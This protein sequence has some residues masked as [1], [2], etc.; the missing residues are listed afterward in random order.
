MDR[1][2]DVLASIR[3]ITSAS[4]SSASGSPSPAADRGQHR[5]P[6]APSE[7]ADYGS[8][9]RSPAGARSGVH[10][11]A[12]RFMLAAAAGGAMVRPSALAAYDVVVALLC[13]AAVTAERRPRSWPS[14][15]CL[16]SAAAAAAV[17][18]ATA[19]VAR[20]SALVAHSPL[21]ELWSGGC[22]RDP[23]AAVPEAVLLAAL[24]L[25]HRHSQ[26]RQIP[27]PAASAG[28]GSVLSGVSP[29]RFE[30]EP[31]RVWTQLREFA[32][33]A[34]PA[35]VACAQPSV[36]TAPHL[37][38]FGY[39]LCRTFIGEAT[40][41]E[42]RAASFSLRVYSAAALLAHVLY[43]GVLVAPS[44]AHPGCTALRWC[45]SEPHALLLGQPWCGSSGLARA[46]VFYAGLSGCAAGGA[47]A[48]YADTPEGLF[49]V[50]TDALHHFS[51]WIA[52]AFMVVSPT[53]CGGVLMMS[54]VAAAHTHA[55]R[56][57]T[58]APATTAR[59][60][61]LV[62]V[63]AA[64]ASLLWGF[65]EAAAEAGSGG[66]P[67]VRLLAQS[68]LC[69]VVAAIG[70]QSNTPQHAYGE[71][72]LF[73][74]RALDH[75]PPG[76][77]K[78]ATLLLVIVSCA[79]FADPVHVVP[80]VAA[81]VVFAAPSR[82]TARAWW[83]RF[84]LA[85]ELPL[86]L[87]GALLLLPADVSASVQSVVQPGGSSP[88]RVFT[89]V[90]C[91][92][93]AAVQSTRFESGEWWMSRRSLVSAETSEALCFCVCAACVL[94]AM[95]A[96]SVA[97]LSLLALSVFVPFVW[98]LAGVEQ[99]SRRRA[100]E[101][102]AAVS[103]CITVLVLGSDLAPPI[104]PWLSDVLTYG[105][106][107]EYVA[108]TLTI[109]DWQVSVCLLAWAAAALSLSYLATRF[110]LSRLSTISV[111]TAA[112]L[113]LGVTELAPVQT[114]LGSGGAAGCAGG[115]RVAHLERESAARAAGLRVGMQLLRVN[116]LPV[117]GL[118][119][120]RDAAAH[121]SASDG[122]PPAQQED[123]SAAEVL[124][125]AKYR[126]LPHLMSAVVP[127]ALLFASLS[128]GGVYCGTS[129]ANCVN[130]SESVAGLIYFVLGVMS[131]QTRCLRL[132]PPAIGKHVPSQDGSTDFTAGHTRLC[133]GVS[134]AFAT[135]SILGSMPSVRDSATALLGR[136]AGA[137]VVVAG[138]CWHDQGQATAATA[139]VLQLPT[140][141]GLICA[142]AAERLLSP[143]CALKEPHD[144]H[145]TAA[146]SRESLVALLAAGML[147]TFNTVWAVL[148]VVVLC[149]AW[150]GRRVTGGVPFWF[151]VLSGAARYAYGVLFPPADHR[152]PAMAD[153]IHDLGAIAGL[154]TPA[155][156]S[157]YWDVSPSAALLVL[158]Y[159]TAYVAAAVVVIERWSRRWELDFD[160]TYSE[161]LTERLLQVPPDLLAEAELPRT[162]ENLESGL[163]AALVLPRFPRWLR[164]R[165]TSARCAELCG[166]LYRRTG[167]VACGLP[168]WRA[169]RHDCFL[170]AS[171]G[172]WVVV[173]TLAGT[174]EGPAA[175]P[176]LSSASPHLDEPPHMIPGWVEVSQQDEQRVAAAVVDVPPVPV[177][178]ALRGAPRVC[179]GVYG[180]TDM[181][182]NGA[183]VWKRRGSGVGRHLLVTPAGYWVFAARLSA[184]AEKAADTPA[185]V[186]VRRHGGVYPHC[187]RGWK[188]VRQAAGAGSVAVRC[189]D[190]AGH[191]AAAQP[192]GD[193]CADCNP[194]VCPLLP[195]IRPPALSPP[196]PH[197]LRIDGTGGSDG[198]YNLDHSYK[199]HGMPVWRREQEAVGDPRLGVDY[200]F[201][202]GPVRQ[203]LPPRFGAEKSAW[204]TVHARSRE[205]VSLRFRG[206]AG[207]VAVPSAL[208][209][210]CR[211]R[212]LTYTLSTV[213][214]CWCVTD[215]REQAEGTPQVCS[216]SA[217]G[218][219]LLP[220]E[221]DEW[222]PQPSTAPDPR[223]TVRDTGDPSQVWFLRFVVVYPYLLVV[224]AVL[225]GMAGLPSV[226]LV[227]ITFSS[228]G[229]AFLPSLDSVTWRANLHWQLLYR[230]YAAVVLLW[231]VSSVITAATGSAWCDSRLVAA[232]GACVGDFD[233]QA[234]VTTVALT[235]LLWQYGRTLDSSTW[236]RILLFKHREARAAASIGAAIADRQAEAVREAHADFDRRRELRRSA[237]KQLRRKRE[238]LHQLWGGLL[239]GQRRAEPA[240]GS[241]LAARPFSPSYAGSSAAVAAALAVASE[242]VVERHRGV[243]ACERVC[244]LLLRRS[245]QSAD[246]GFLRSMAR[247]YGW[248]VA[249]LWVL[250]EVAFS[251]TAEACYAVTGAHFLAD[252]CVT[253]VLV[254]MSVLL[255]AI[256]SNPRPLFGYWELLLRFYGCVFAFKAALL[257]LQPAASAPLRLMFGWKV[258]LLRDSPSQPFS[259][260]WFCQWE[261]AAFLLIVLH[262][263]GLK[264]HWGLSTDVDVARAEEG[265]SDGVKED[266]GCAVDVEPADDGPLGPWTRYRR[267]L[268]N[269]RHKRGGRDLYSVAFA[270][271]F[272]S[273]VFLIF[274]YAPIMGSRVGFL[275][276]I[277]SNVIPAGLVV[278]VVVLFAVMIT[279]RVVYLSR[280]IH[281][282]AVLHC[283]LCVTYLVAY[284]VYTHAAAG[285]VEEGPLRQRELVG[286]PA[287]V[288]QALCGIKLLYLALS[289]MQLREGY[290]FAERRMFF[291]GK[292][293][294]ASWYLYLGCY[295]I[296]FLYELRC[297]V[298]WA[299]TKTSLKLQYWL[300]LEDV[301][302]E[303]HL[304][305][306]QK[307]DDR[308]TPPGE[309]PRSWKCGS[310]FAYCGAITVLVFFPLAW[311]SSLSPAFVTSDVVRASFKVDLIT[312]GRS[313]GIYSGSYDVT[314]EERRR[315]ESLNVSLTLPGPAWGRALEWTRPSLSGLGLA[316]GVA[317]TTQ[318][319]PFPAMS[320]SVWG[321]SGAALS[322][323]RASLRRGSAV[324]IQLSLKTHR[325][326]APP[327]IAAVG[328]AQTGTLGPEA[329]AALRGQL[330]ALANGTAANGTAPVTLRFAYT[331][332]A[333]VGTGMT[334]FRDAEKPGTNYVACN[335]SV[336]P[337]SSPSDSFWKVL[338]STLFDRGNPPPVAAAESAVPQGFLSG[339]EAACLQGDPPSVSACA[340]LRY[341]SAG[342]PPHWGHARG[343]Y[344]VA[345]SDRVTAGTGV[346][347]VI[348][349]IGVVALYTTFVFAVHRVL[350]AAFTGEAHRIQ[351]RAMESP[352]S[353]EEVISFIHAARQEGDLA[354]EKGLYDELVNLFRSPEAMREWVRGFD[355]APGAVASTPPLHPATDDAALSPILGPHT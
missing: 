111:P 127:T 64:A 248:G 186:T 274:G 131:A 85:V 223:I 228:A 174:A 73:V 44:A 45:S 88:Q 272:L 185:V 284:L 137:W 176:H 330:D 300:R 197:L 253:T 146:R 8:I 353:V 155:L 82:D 258:L 215:F 334:F 7:P 148:T 311:Y 329:R 32:R 99:L 276:S 81:A 144:P 352:Q 252:P 38:V 36:V 333:F 207:L 114:C 251:W 277:T 27:P 306:C 255:Y 296:P 209:A 343:P 172:H 217:H 66:S 269:E 21:L 145:R 338:C 19:L 62:L 331:P 290:A 280:R 205:S 181:Q 298:D 23:V 58:S 230:L 60:A 243:S 55:R 34:L 126:W 279:E 273:F 90:C 281:A 153:W 65:A 214:G 204:A 98:G 227:S 135:L 61:L 4:D 179:C 120:V 13:S 303:V 292:H 268:L 250:E 270:V 95:F 78:M 220:S 24:L 108:A 158:F 163:E 236:A 337:A 206:V 171:G 2:Q 288:L 271:D 196:P 198:V 246:L 165:P 182:V 299:F 37:L 52:A 191:P 115:L 164:V 112:L 106:K 349:S 87:H 96:S 15:R 203:M 254:V 194:P 307:E 239:A 344:L 91:L 264:Y 79:G 105:S 25:F 6:D 310:F 202:V 83:G 10:G 187:A 222:E 138:G 247:K 63:V 132:L 80:F 84:L 226:S 94:A 40:L 305:L 70:S 287:A 318:L 216:V 212:Q 160:G 336:V 241:L 113:E 219:A 9:Q 76:T 308:K 347:R 56:S 257:S 102:S 121:S 210:E 232:V 156:S 141:V 301:S 332:F 109:G 341:D 314:E 12:L 240:S 195:S 159:T 180:I 18:P 225:H 316:H 154:D 218:E 116:G 188:L 229:I 231:L 26:A 92:S 265:L 340:A 267:N 190:Q 266:G 309:Y 50:S 175:T 43:I 104:G 46:V 28:V 169:T 234:R 278:A 57:A 237:L 224:A 200:A 59:I 101:F 346:W 128:G 122:G 199:V 328:S 291:A 173:E 33:V 67:L 335:F 100:A 161:G 77:A 110:P 354:L 39:R 133:L 69:A 22:V 1:P 29:G 208:W 93:A 242:G 293:D 325:T 30:P 143:Y 289:A 5:S 321:V 285:S 211:P 189:M 327:S 51:L 282:K 140:H 151:A 72:T 260:L 245:Y 20:G 262:R 323:F 326:K 86:V 119:C 35:A 107:P 315:L 256:C 103:W 74:L 97:P 192:A 233:A 134:T 351:V 304:G 149:V 124:R 238:R 157:G 31:V 324:G 263:R 152:F 147:L 342:S 170:R 117:S 162:D 125:P 184:D 68:A 297:V 286:P 14:L 193:D 249:W 136:S 294:L 313:Y 275:E 41:S 49:G 283:T 235:A 54:A 319:V 259:L 71:P 178:L 89:L 317:R 130:V 213:G 350:R 168:V 48:G 42:G 142:C 167:D 16:R 177:E 295:A 47:K 17:L 355:A 322:S 261:L 139:C 150:R 201:R 221:I 3:S 312:D 118:S 320:E 339:P 345:M 183:P 129:T 166:G 75:L 11:S 302:H 53:P 123:T 348:P 244:M